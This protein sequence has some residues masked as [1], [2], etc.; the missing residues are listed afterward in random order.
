[1]S[2]VESAGGRPETFWDCRYCCGELWIE[3]GNKARIAAMIPVYRQ[4]QGQGSGRLI[5]SFIVFFP[6]RQRSHCSWTLIRKQG[7]DCQLLGL[8]PFCDPFLDRM[9]RGYSVGTLR[10]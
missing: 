6:F 5:D 2:R 4:G 1:M 9:M 7:N 10:R 8:T 3:T